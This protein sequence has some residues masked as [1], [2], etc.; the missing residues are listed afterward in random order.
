MNSHRFYQPFVIKNTDLERYA[1]NLMQYF[2]DKEDYAII[3]FEEKILENFNHD[4][5]NIIYIYNAPLINDVNIETLLEKLDLLKKRLRKQFLLFNQNILVL[6]TNCTIDFSKVDIPD[7]VDFIN[8]SERSFLNKS[9]IIRQIYPQLI[10]YPLDLSFEILTYRLNEIGIAYAQNI[11][12]IFNKN[13]FL[14]NLFL[15]LAIFIIN[16]ILPMISRYLIMT[17]EGLANHQ[18]YTLL[19]NNL[20]D[21]NLI[22]IILSGFFILSFG[23]RLEKIYGSL[24]FL[25]IIFITMIFSNAFLLAFINSDTYVIGFTP[26][27]Y[28]YVGSFIYVILIFRRFLAYMLKRILVFNVLLIFLMFILGDVVSLVSLI[29]AFISGFIAS[30]IIGIPKAKNKNITHRLIAAVFTV[31]LV[32]LL[33]SIGLK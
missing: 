3:N 13:H 21:V 20:V 23:I 18:Y 14:I 29:G 33:V 25:G 32:T 15:L 1:F 10:S 31:I 30:F 7:N 28:T 5:Y 2:L 19:T 16:Y 9:G 8:V 27:I 6:G 26:I 24:R 4:Y 11:K 12:K 17:K 22:S